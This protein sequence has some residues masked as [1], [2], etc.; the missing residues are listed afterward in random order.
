MTNQRMEEQ[1]KPRGDETAPIRP[2]KAAT[3]SQL[4]EK[5]RNSG[6]G[7]LSAGESRSMI[8]LGNKNHQT[9]LRV[10]DSSP[11]RR[12]EKIMDGEADYVVI[13]CSD[14]RI[15]TLDSEADVEKF[16]GV[17]IRVAGNVVPHEGLSLDEIKQAVS[18]VKEG[19]LVIIEGHCKCGAVG[20]RVKWNHAGRPD[21][22]STPLNTLLHAVFGDTPQENAMAQ[23]E[24]LKGIVG[25][26]REVAAVIY[27]WEKGTVEIISPEPSETAR[28]LKSKWERF[29][30]D[31]NSDGKLAERLNETQ[32]PHSVVVASNNMPFSID[33][34]CDGEQN[35]IFATTGSEEGL[36]DFDEASALYAAEHLGPKHMAF[37][38]PMST[39]M[40]KMF[41]KWEADLRSMPEIAEK[42]DSGAIKITRM[43]Y[44]LSNGAL[45]EV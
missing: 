39:G 11:Q 31:A 37:I 4:K 29:H 16:V 10:L 43:G 3:L 45:Q 19:G 21:T 5:H 2:S 14:A 17:Q 28:I 7:A 20:E 35:E 1:K 6:Q 27:D 22:G 18:R 9:K 32:K 30:Q 23:Y 13:A 36:D 38:A 25:P 42:L 40:E 33:T 26:G 15:P 44:N 34:V 8:L 41:D 12:Y 24:T